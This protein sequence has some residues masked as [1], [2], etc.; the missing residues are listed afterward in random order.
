MTNFRTIGGG[1][2]LLICVSAV[3]G[4]VHAAAPASKPAVWIDADFPGGNIIV[5]RIEGDHVFLRPDLRDTSRWWFYWYF[6]VRGAAGRTMTFTFADGNPIGVRGPAVSDNGGRTWSW[7]GAEAAHEASFTYTFGE[8]AG[9]I[10]FC[11]TIPYL[12][13][14][15]RSFLEAHKGNAHLRVSTL[16]KTRK[17]RE[18]ECLRVGKI[19]G[20]PAHRVLLAARHH[21]CE[22]MASFT[23]EGLVQ[24]VVVDDDQQWLRQN[25]EFL[26]VPFVDKDGV[27]DGDQGKLR[28]PRD[29]NR[30]YVGESI[31]TSTRALREMVPRW[32]EGKL[33][34]V[35]DLH[36]PH[37]RG[38][39]N[40]VV[41]LVGLPGEANWERLQDFSAVLESLSPRA[42]PYQAS[43]NLPF[44]QEW[45]T[46]DNTK[47]GKSFA[48]WASEIPGVQ[49]ASTLEIAYANARGAVVTSESA[50]GL[51]RDIALAIAR[52]LRGEMSNK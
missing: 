20:T 28:S 21:A 5:D 35:L 34:I 13:A 29:H 48:R 12:E 8:R 33:R 10:R 43:D 50:R 15:L 46:E 19:E 51:G 11:F 27:E 42:L 1:V 31:Y 22:T 16:C 39:R 4:T 32:A 14:N 41:Y 30:D 6:R 38:K 3:P 26:V 49:V 40:E 25:V 36:C 52:Y 47:E 44:G 9:D 7:L 37:I 2:L 45:N 23:L 24:S 18:V 17:G